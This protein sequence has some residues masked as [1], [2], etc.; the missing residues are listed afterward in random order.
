M[1]ATKTVLKLTHQE[2][3][4][5]IAGTAGS[6][7]IDLQTDLLH[8]KQQLSGT[9]VVNI[10]GCQWVGLDGASITIARNSVNVLTLPG[11]GADFLEFGAGYA[12]STENTSDV[13]V[14]IAGAEAQCY[15]TLR[16]VSGYASEIETS[17]F[18][19]YDDTNAIGS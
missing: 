2:A 6:A 14:T 9:Q 5:K 10:T 7:T 18:S 12:E 19:V 16:K 8:D 1:A 11:A 17:Q 13:V 4:I 15:I 3:V